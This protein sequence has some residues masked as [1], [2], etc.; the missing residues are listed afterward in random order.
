MTTPMRTIALATLAI[1]L[2][3]PPFRA[4]GVERPGA[5]PAPVV[6]VVLKER[7]N[8]SNLAAVLRRTPGANGTNIIA[9]RR[10]AATPELLATALATLARSRATAGEAPARKITVAIRDG[11]KLR[12]L[13]ASERTRL[14]GM[15]GRLVAASPQAV[16]GVGYVPAITVDLSQ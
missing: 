3:V 8:P 14:D 12:P 6:T 1:S 9:L 16:P 10:S 4:Q 13:S 2:S 11:L 5:P 15:I 7:F